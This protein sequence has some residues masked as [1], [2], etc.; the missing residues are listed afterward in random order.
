MTNTVLVTGANRGIGLEFVKQYLQGGDEVIACARSISGATQLQTIISGATN[1]SIM[2]LDVTNEQ[3]VAT[4]VTGL[5]GRP[6]DILINNAGTFAD[7]DQ[8][9]IQLPFATFKQVFETNLMG[10]F[11][12]IQ[13]LLSN[14]LASQEK[15]IVAISS[16]L[17]SITHTTEANYYA[18]RSSKAALNMLMRTISLD[19]KVKKGKAFLFHPGWVQTDM[20]GGSAVV[21]PT[22]SV[23]GMRRL[24]DADQCVQKNGFYDYQGKLLSW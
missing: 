6:I 23:N 18:Y 4:L 10:I 13:S 16:I 9:L 17:G 2:Q 20:G 8:S 22:D 24:I 7:K 3:S 21:T 11:S 5:N 14:V 1:A 12:V 15:K 19:I